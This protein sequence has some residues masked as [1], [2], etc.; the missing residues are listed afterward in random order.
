MT[1]RP[2]VL[3]AAVG[4]SASIA[5][6]PT[7]SRPLGAQTDIVPSPPSS[8]AA[9]ASS[10]PQVPGV[11]AG[12]EPPPSPPDVAARSLDDLPVLELHHVHSD[13]LIALDFE[14][15]DFLAA[16]EQFAHLDRRTLTWKPCMTKGLR[17]VTVTAGWGRW[18]EDTYIAFI[19]LDGTRHV[20]R[21][22]RFGRTW[23]HPSHAAASFRAGFY[24]AHAPGL[25]L[26]ELEVVGSASGQSGAGFRL[27]EKAAKPTLRTL[28]QKFA[29]DACLAKESS[30]YD[31]AV[32]DDRLT[33]AC[34][35]GLEWWIGTN[36]KS[37]HLRLPLEEGSYRIVTQGPQPLLV[38]VVGGRVIAKLDQGRW[39]RE[40]APGSSALWL[41]EERDDAVLTFVER[42]AQTLW[43]RSFDGTWTSEKISFEP[44]VMATAPDGE[45]LALAGETVWVKPTQG[46]WTEHRL[47]AGITHPNLMVV[48]DVLLLTSSE[49]GTWSRSPLRVSGEV[50]HEWVLFPEK[51]P[52]CLR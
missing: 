34:G 49:G 4:L 12:S 40:K 38:P 10:P 45:R 44:W 8:S 16:M 47:P 27:I 42:D 29:S 35:R 15:A 3:L 25:G 24:R 28:P 18:P 36:P 39:T 13:E 17:M 48:G 20:A 21:W 19:A 11:A 2:A 50:S 14:G 23:R 7:T 5:C 32:L 30:I 51:G 6:G 41:V 33:V 46:A 26:V 22:D 31:L 52:P 1:R 37:E 9:V 43:E